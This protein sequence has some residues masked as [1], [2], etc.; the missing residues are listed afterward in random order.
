[1][2]AVIVTSSPTWAQV[3]LIIAAALFFIGALM[4]GG[5]LKWTFGHVCVALG[6]VAFALSFLWL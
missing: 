3:L 1:M 4:H 2:I 6:L 5:I